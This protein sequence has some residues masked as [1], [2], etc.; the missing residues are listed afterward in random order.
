MGSLAYFSFIHDLKFKGKQRVEHTW[1]VP[2]QFSAH[3]DQ[4]TYPDRF[5]YRGLNVR[6]I[7]PQGFYG[8]S[9]IKDIGE[10]C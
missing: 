9:K 5:Y 4:E 1:W 7:A 8:K 10:A 6:E 2:I 3:D